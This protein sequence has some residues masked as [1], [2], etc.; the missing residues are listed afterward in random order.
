MNTTLLVEQAVNYGVSL[1]AGKTR[2]QRQK[3]PE[4][5][6]PLVYSERRQAIEINVLDGWAEWG[7]KSRLATHELLV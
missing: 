5:S 4:T 2:G 1:K 3:K 6:V 7:E